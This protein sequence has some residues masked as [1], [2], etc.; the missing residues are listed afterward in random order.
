MKSKCNLPQVVTSHC[1]KQIGE[2]NVVK[3]ILVQKLVCDIFLY[4]IIVA[5]G[6]FC[7]IKSYFDK[8]KSS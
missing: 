8:K 2:K 3:Q 4:P 6:S 7:V 5:S 1:D